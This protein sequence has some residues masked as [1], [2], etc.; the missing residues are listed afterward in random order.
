[1]FCPNCKTE[2]REG[3]GQCSDCGATLVESLGDTTRSAD[4]VPELLWAGNSPRIY[5]DFRSALE[6]AGVPFMDQAG[7]HF[8]YSSLRPPLEIW[9]SKRNHD[10]AM[11]VRQF[12]TGESD[13]E[14]EGQ[15]SFAELDQ[16]ASRAQNP[17]P[18]PNRPSRLWGFFGGS[19]PGELE[20]G[21]PVEETDADEGV[22]ERRL[23]KDG[24][25]L[26]GDY[27]SSATPESF[28][29]EFYPEDA[30]SRVYQ[31]ELDVAQNL[32]ACL[33]EVGI[34]SALEVPENGVSEVKVCVL[35]EHEARAKEIIREVIEGT[36]PE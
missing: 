34:P 3:F 14:L 7:P 29:G 2:Y 30:T 32:K 8:L 12:V 25:N 23:P 18:D 22:A 24:S 31:G 13:E 27:F 28:S 35:P 9:I 17:Y 1:M 20:T 36:P 21:A 16:Q 10:A 11:K 6:A 19:R 26:L 15:E 33:R 4:D 5:Q